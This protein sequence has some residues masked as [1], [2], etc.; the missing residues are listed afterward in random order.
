MTSTYI[1]YKVYAQDIQRTLKRTAAEPQVEREAAYYKDHIGKI[2]SVDEFLKNDRVY[3]Y[4]MRAGGLTDMIDAKAFMRKVLTSDLTDPK[5]FARM[6]ADTRYQNF[7][8][9]FNFTSTGSVLA[10]PILAQSD[11]QENETIGLYSAARVRAG[12]SAS[13]EVAAYRTQIATV[14]TVDDFLAN[15]RLVDVALKAVGLTPGAADPALLRNVLTSDLTDPGS[16]ANQK[17]GAYLALAKA[18]GFA[19][20][21]SAPAGGPQS[22]AQIG[23]IVLGY[24][25]VMGAGSSPPAAAFRTEQYRAF[26][27][28]VTSL[29]DLLGNEQALTVI[30]TA[31]GLDPSIQPAFFDALFTSDLT[32]PDSFANTFENGAYKPI[33]QAFKFQPDGSLPAG[34]VAQDDAQITTVVDAYMT[35]YDTAAQAQDRSATTY[36]KS[37]MLAKVG[38]AVGLRSVDEL[39]NN[40]KLY[41]YVMTAYDLDPATE[42]RTVI[43]KVLTSDFADPASF[44][45]R[46]GN[47]K[48]RTLAAAFNFAADGKT[49][50]AHAAQ[51]GRDE[52]ALIRRYNAAI[53]SNGTTAEKQNLKAANTYYDQVVTAVDTVDQLLAD[54]KVVTYILRAYGL[55]TANVSI[56]TLKQVLTSDPLDPKSAAAKLGDPR[57]REIAAAF[58]FDS[59]GNVKRVPASEVQSR[60]D[61]LKTADQFLYQTMET[62]AGASSEGVRLSLYFRRKAPGLASAYSILADKALIEVT[63]TALGLPASMSNLAIETQAALIDTK[64]KVADLKDPTKLDKFI[65]R[66]GAM[67]DLAQ[68]QAAQGSSPALA[69]F[70]RSTSA[71]LGF[72]SSLISRLQQV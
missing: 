55:E 37:R 69:L 8:A 26:V 53:A 24:Y 25:D 71:T 59:A 50:S 23:T 31:Y 2:K 67:Y 42:S 32:D 46:S 64:L 68:S 7:A 54:K 10:D 40:A 29:D 48:Y 62:N 9:A 12:Q 13:T 11:D 34:V 16:M 35:R 38:D 14:T 57:Y 39:L 30:K 21:G 33:V 72:D 51:I 28:T 43:R 45:N 1:N 49:T 52:L 65:A 4:A 15:S 41:D 56:A 61:M 70:S 58:N 3:R 19:A 18:F 60:T 22:Q 27:P 5:S 20:D 47:P 63:R 66:F 6:L 44:A 36:Y 17:G